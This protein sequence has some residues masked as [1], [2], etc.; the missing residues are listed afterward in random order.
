MA[1]YAIGDVQGCCDELLKLLSKIAFNFGTDTLWLTG[2]LV[3]RGPKS[4]E[5]LR[6]AM[7]HDY[8]V[9]TVLGNHDLHLLAVA[10]AGARLKKGDTL[11]PI[12]N[13]VDNKVM[14]EWLRHQPM[15]V[16]HNHYAM[17]HAG[18]LPDWDID[19]AHDHAEQIEQ[20][21][22]SDRFEWL[23]QNMYGNKP[24][25]EA[26]ISSELDRLRFSLNVMTRMRAITTQHELDF[27]FKG[28]IDDLPENLTPWFAAEHPAWADHKIVF[29]HWSALGLHVDEHVIGLDTGAVWG[30]ELTAIS[31]PDG[32]ITQVN[33]HKQTQG[34]VA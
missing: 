32:R 27:D 3:N 29:G 16:A 22:V 26:D 31:L 6:F 17:V 25:Q 28:E 13:A 33:G 9:Q 34:T 19:Q 11:D 24:K 30:R 15:F 18:L 23:L 21:L 4:L 1:H 8:C 14:L 12:L 10:Y 5:V 7:K 20:I 2:D